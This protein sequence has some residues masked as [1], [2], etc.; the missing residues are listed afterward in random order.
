MK[1]IAL[2]IL[3]TFVTSLVLDSC[4]VQKRYHR[5]GF[6]VN[7]NHTS[8]RMKKDKHPSASEEL[9]NEVLA[10]ETNQSVDEFTLAVKNS[11]E[12]NGANLSTDN[13]DANILVEESLKANENSEAPSAATTNH[14]SKI[15]NVVNAKKVKVSASKIANHQKS[16]THQIYSKSE[17][18]DVD[19]MMILMII[20]CFILPPIAVAIATHVNWISILWNIIFCLLGFLPGVIHAL[21]HVYRN[22]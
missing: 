16:N 14:T 19:I 9:V 11:D 13:G 8:V 18:Q 1:K 5:T 12:L 2:L 6:N 15:V 17:K 22:R 10:E 4:S 20:L 21:Y 7:W 3:V